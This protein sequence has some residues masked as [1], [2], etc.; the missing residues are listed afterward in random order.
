LKPIIFTLLDFATIGFLAIVTLVASIVTLISDVSLEGKIL[1]SVVCSIFSLI[2]AGVLIG[3]K[4]AIDSCEFFTNDGCGV[5]NNSS[6]KITK[7]D[8]DNEIQRTKNLWAPIVS[9]AVV[10]DIFTKKY[11]IVF[12]DLVG[13]DPRTKVQVAGVTISSKFSVWD[14]KIIIYKMDTL[15]IPTSALSHELGHLIYTGKYGIFDNE[16]THKFMADNNLP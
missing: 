11:L 2:Y 7:E 3:R 12:E 8:V 16:T 15:T 5:I 10:N 14:G 9:W 6:N 13:E 1:M 4:R